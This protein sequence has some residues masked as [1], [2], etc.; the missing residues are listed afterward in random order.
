VENVDRRH[1]TLTLHDG[2]EPVTTTIP[3]SATVLVFCREAECTLEV[4]ESSEVLDRRKK[5]FV[6]RSGRLRRAPLAE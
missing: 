6:M 2:A 5:S 1:R 3:A 4:G